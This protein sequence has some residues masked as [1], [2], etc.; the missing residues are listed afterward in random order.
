MDCDGLKKGLLIDTDGSLFGQP[1]TVFSQSEYLWNDQAHGV[2]DFRIPRT[3][4]RNETPFRGILR[5]SSC[6]YQ[7]SWQMYLCPNVT[8]YR[9][10]IIESLDADTETRRISPVAVISNGYL[11]LLNGPQ[12]HGWCNGYTCQRRLSTFMSIVRARQH[13]DIYFTGTSPTHLRFRL[14]NSDRS[15]VTTI[16]LFYNSLQQVDVYAN[17]Q[18]VPPAN[19]NPNSSTLILLDQPAT[20]TC[21]A[22]PGTNYFNR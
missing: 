14:L 13:A 17:N 6:R 21:S 8:D 12:D 18:F 5:A 10:L 1:S 11:D 3:V 19:R 9:M 20:V 4:P 16:G 22:P 15:I 2:G 7:S